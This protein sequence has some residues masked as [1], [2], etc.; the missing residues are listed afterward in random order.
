MIQLRTSATI[1]ADLLTTTRFSSVLLMGQSTKGTM[2][3]EKRLP[4]LGQFMLSK[5]K[6]CE[7]TNALQ[8][9]IPACMLIM[10]KATPLDKQY[11]YLGD[12][13]RSPS[14]EEL[15]REEH[16]EM[17]QAYAENYLSEDL[18]SW[19]K[20]LREE[21]TEAY[22][23]DDALSMYNDLEGFIK[24]FDYVPSA[25]TE[26]MSTK[27]EESKV[28]RESAWALFFNM[29]PYTT[30]WMV[31]YL[32]YKSVVS[33]ADLLDDP[34]ILRKGKVT[35]S[36]IQNSITEDLS[37]LSILPGRCTSFAIQVSSHLEELPHNFD[38]EY[39]DL[40]G[41][42]VARCKLTGILIDSGGPNGP[43][44]LPDGK[45]VAAVD[46][47]RK[48][49]WS[50][51]SGSFTYSSKNRRGDKIEVFM[52][53]GHMAF[54]F[55]DSKDSTTRKRISLQI[56]VWKYAFANSQAKHTWNHS[57]FSGMI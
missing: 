36:D 56:R 8:Y 40:N 52:G 13:E 24:D 15:Y 1:R 28:Q 39:Y 23:F 35:N 2:E 18:P 41:H 25:W 45:K 11:R 34:N 47:P 16:Q 6:Y 37:F 19:E 20:F 42:R 48:R 53:N 14:E 27:D 9:N 30:F 21:A 17:I 50:Y 5:P 51:E 3:P 4:K 12:V 44:N 43:I 29:T 38:F 7:N 26:Y 33:Y 22:G 57:V 10:V 54:L 49:K 32:L 55:T 31:D 46:D